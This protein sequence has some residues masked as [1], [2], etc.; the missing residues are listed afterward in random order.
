MRMLSS[1]GETED[2]KRKT[3]NG[4]RLRE[5]TEAAAAGG[6]GHTDRP[7]TVSRT[8]SARRASEQDRRLVEQ[9]TNT[10]R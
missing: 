9:N 10:G 5:R 6:G 3:V 4:G 8:H 7:A 2:R 1:A